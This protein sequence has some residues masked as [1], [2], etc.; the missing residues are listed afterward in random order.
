MFLLVWL[1]PI[2]I[3]CI[4]TMQ[5]M[6]MMLVVRDRDSHGLRLLPCIFIEASIPR[7]ATILILR[8][9]IVRKKVLAKP[10]PRK[11]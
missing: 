8:I 11:T 5:M 1:G 4:R 6:T 7:E 3:L 9:I 10:T 2:C